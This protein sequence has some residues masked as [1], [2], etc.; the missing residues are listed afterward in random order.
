MGS[1][2][3]HQGLFFKGDSV[4]AAAG[5]DYA[6]SE[7]WRV[8]YITMCCVAVLVIIFASH[9]YNLVSNFKKITKINL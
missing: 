4:V 3:Y 6:F 2:I 8:L 9:E 1:V 5:V 7:R